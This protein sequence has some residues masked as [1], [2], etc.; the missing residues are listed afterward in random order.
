MLKKTFRSAVS[1]A[2]VVC[3]LLGMSGNALAVLA[4]DL[5][6]DPD[7]NKDGKINYVSLGDSMSNG[8][9]LPGYEL[10]SG[11]ETYAG[12]AYANQFAEW[13]EANSNQSVDH[14]QLA[15]SGIRAEDL[16]WLLELDYNDQEAITLIQDLIDGDWDE[17]KWNA[18]FTTGDYWTLEEI[19]NHSRLD[20]T[21]L[22]IVG[23]TNY[24]DSSKSFPGKLP[25]DYEYPTTYDKTA[26]MSY[27]KN[28]A[29][30][31]A[32]V[33]Q[34]FQDHVAEADI[35]SL[36]VGNGNLG[37]FGFG[38]I[39]DVIGFDG[40]GVVGTGVYR[41]EAAIRELDPEM[42][43]KVLEL[44]AALYDVVVAKAGMDINSNETLKALADIVVYIGLS[45]VLSYA[46]SIEAILQ[47][48]PDAEIIMVPVMNTF[49]EE[50]EGIEG[51]SIGDL[52]EAIVTPM[53]AFLAGLPTYMQ[54][55]NNS[56]YK[57]AKFYYAEIGF[58]ECMVER[59]GELINN[60]DSVVRSRFV[61]E[62]VGTAA[63]PGMV[64]GLM[65]GVELVEGITLV[66]VT[67]NEI[68][69]Y[70]AL[71]VTEQ[72]AYA[73]QNKQKAL[74]IA[75]YLAFEDAIIASKDA[76]VTLDS[77]LG[78]GNLGT[79][80]FTPVMED[81]M[82]N[83]GNYTDEQIEAAAGVVVAGAAQQGQ[84]IAV[85]Q[86]KKLAA[87]S[88][89]QLKAY[90]WSSVNDSFVGNT[91]HTSMDDVLGCNHEHILGDACA[92]LAQ[93]FA[94]YSALAGNTNMLCML[95][96]LPETLSASL[97][98]DATVSGLLALFARCMI[99]NGLGAHPSAN[100]HKALADAVIEAYANDYTTQDKTINNLKLATGVVADLVA[101]YYDDAYAYAYAN[102]GEYIAVANTAIDAAIAKL[103][104]LDLSDSEM[105][106]AF[107][108]EVA[109]EVEEIIEALTAAK[110]L[111]N[112]ADELDQESLDLLIAALEEAG[113]AAANLE[114][115]LAQAG[116]DVTE[117]VIVPAIEAAIEY[118][119]EVA[120]PAA[121]EAAEKMAEE[122]LNYLVEKLEEA[123]SIL[124][125]AAVEAAKKYA[126]EVADA[127]YDYLY[128]NPEEVIEF[129]KT[130]GPYV[131]E[132]T[133]EYGD[134]ILGVVG[135]VLYAY[136]EDIAALII[137]NHEAILSGLVAWAE[138][139]GENTIQLIQ[140]YAEA[141]GL[142]DAVREQMEALKTELEGMI[143]ELEKQAEALKAELEELKAQL[144]N[145]SAELK[146]EIE[147]AIAEVE[148][149][150]AEIEAAIAELQAELAQVVA[151]I[152]AVVEAVEAVFEEL[153]DLAEAIASGA[154]DAIMDAIDAVQTALDNLAKVVEAAE[155]TIAYINELIDA[156]QKLGVDI[157]EAVEDL[158]NA[159]ENLDD[160]IAGVIEGAIDELEAEIAAA[161]EE[162]KAEIEAAI[163]ELL[164]KV[165]AEAIAALEAL[166]A[167]LEAQVEELLNQAAAELVEIMT[168]LFN[169]ATHTD[170]VITED[171]AYVAIGDNTAY[172]EL[173]NAY[174]AELVAGTDKVGYEYPNATLVQS[175]TI[176]DAPAAIQSNLA[177]I[178]GADLIS[179]GY[180]ND[181][182]ATQAIDAMMAALIYGEFAEYDWV[183]LLGEDGA[184]YAA[185][186][187][188]ELYS[189]LV[190]MGL[191]DV[192]IPT[193]KA[194][195]ADAMM[196]AVET[197][198][199]NVAVYGLY[200]P[201]VI[202]AI[203]E[204]NPDAQI[205]VV[206]MSNPFA[207]T[208]FTFEDMAIN[209]GEYVEYI[210]DA[211]NIYGVTY[212]VLT[213]NVTFVP[214][215]EAESTVSNQTIEMGLAFVFEYIQGKVTFTT[216][217][218][219]N[220][221]IAE[222]IKNAL[223]VTVE[224]AAL[225][226]DA[227]SDGDVDIYDAQMVLAYVTGDT[228]KN[229]LIDLSVSDVDADGDV[230]IY[231]AQAILAYVTGGTEKLPA[232]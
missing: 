160:V 163:N 205:I 45:M 155:Q 41:I 167:E 129:V 144:E 115:L 117:L 214:A 165:E 85:E 34:Y 46:G 88:D 29:M 92:T 72:A 230:D 116:A 13:L 182:F 74:S 148:A 124:L 207:G 134:E 39:L 138:I 102:S 206:G 89:E 3:L 16:H 186:Y 7:V 91:G 67:L 38:R 23:G 17:E 153:N 47:L 104:A 154:A 120:I 57:N 139:H 123:Y 24:D 43:A 133:E 175:N 146:A 127:I 103:A 162:L 130:Y 145:A 87:M 100:G 193:A 5:N 198:V 95:L 35:V 126:P 98:K 150:I 220:A 225:L 93:T 99:G 151:E 122:A 136:G 52:M 185:E 96:A 212:A 178:A 26:D 194:S 179:I 119:E 135:Y 184:A 201:E 21:Y 68:K 223:T 8:Y 191:A 4:A 50:G 66:P 84:T 213:E 118:V 107:K 227:D 159:V 106:P 32:L 209:V 64:W 51:V 60:V 177:A 200:L 228:S 190:A 48:N 137:E 187:M 171:S 141:L 80:L 166:A 217:E 78:L 15:M 97:Q 152:E 189:E 14:A 180:G 224:P 157:Y 211:A 183:A 1:F 158:K 173:L 22:A 149:A 204:I 36:A 76:S 59:Y 6:K 81:F 140:V 202:S 40:D 221:Y 105:T 9:G 232:Q 54:A 125:D 111:L 42:Q 112:G 218:A 121:I 226:G 172:A 53:N 114:K 196:A 75:V 222:Q 28:R 37:V 27:G 132:L 192:V 156:L 142:C 61:E 79:E 82:A 219:G 25:A 2:L 168:D 77:V 63:K 169:D 199:Y 203:Q 83:S 110:A 216:T 18:K 195:L 108:A 20:A 188:T 164:A 55:V 33:A 94:V 101:E 62:I 197:Y 86:V 176:A 113:E 131:L 73:A 181:T 208:V 70:E 90:I 58:V 44:K 12:V 215:P 69:A 65:A 170:Y 56:V 109:R 31:V 19:C 128:N 161:I 143:A 174:L 231:D 71:G 229:E 30:K 49:V 10:N 210:V 147:A 11:V